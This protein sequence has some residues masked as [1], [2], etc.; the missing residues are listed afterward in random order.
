MPSI[1]PYF[2]HGVA[3]W[4]NERPYV[5][6][7]Q[8]DRATAIGFPLGG[9][10]VVKWLNDGSLADNDNRHF[11]GSVNN[12][13][14]YG[15]MIHIHGQWGNVSIEH[16]PFLVAHAGP[17]PAQ[18]YDFPTRDSLT[19]VNCRP[20]VNPIGT[21]ARIA[22]GTYWISVAN[23][24]GAGTTYRWV[25]IIPRVD[26]G[27]VTVYANLN[28]PDPNVPPSGILATKYSITVSQDDLNYWANTFGY[29]G[30]S[31]PN[32]EPS[33]YYTICLTNNSLHEN[34]GHDGVFYVQPSGYREYD[35]IPDRTELNSRVAGEKALYEDEFLTA[36]QVEAGTNVTL[37]WRNIDGSLTGYT[38]DPTKG[39]NLVIEATGGGGAT[40]H[41]GANANT[42]VYYDEVT[43]IIRFQNFPRLHEEP[44]D[45]LIPIEFQVYKAPGDVG[46][47]R[48]YGVNNNLYVSRGEGPAEFTIHTYPMVDAGFIEDQT[49]NHLRFRDTP[50]IQWDLLGTTMPTQTENGI[51]Y[52]KG[53]VVRANA[54]TAFTGWYLQELNTVPQTQPELISNNEIV[55]VEG[56]NGVVCTLSLPNATTTRLQIDRPLRIYRDAIPVGAPNTVQLR[57]RCDLESGNLNWFGLPFLASS[58]PSRVVMHD[59]LEMDTVPF[60][61]RDRESEGFPGRRDVYGF[62]TQPHCM[63]QTQWAMDY[64]ALGGDG[65]TLG[66]VNNQVIDELRLGCLGLFQVNA[67]TLLPGCRVDYHVVDGDRLNNF[68]RPNSPGPVYF[69]TR[70]AATSITNNARYGN[71]VPRHPGLFRITYR[72]QGL[73]QIPTDV[74]LNPVIHPR[75]HSF[76]VNDDNPTN[77][78][79][80]GAEPPLPKHFLPGVSVVGGMWSLSDRIPQIGTPLQSSQAYAPVIN[81]RPWEVYGEGFIA[82]DGHTVGNT[83]V[84]RYN[85]GS[86]E[87]RIAFQVCYMYMSIEKVA[88]LRDIYKGGWY[89]PYQDL[90]INNE[91]NALSSNYIYNNF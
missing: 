47:I 48:A 45:G 24:T 42:S 64:D 20:D 5:G 36:S 52:R 61:V 18:N 15:L 34:I 63:A 55:Q 4:M 10:I 57:F 6:E 69:T 62:V 32:L 67:Q 11:R 28:P 41:Q 46:V 38:T 30:Q 9:N 31:L 21:I 56:V 70:Y 78:V 91:I 51:I 81:S 77:P 65:R 43:N 79:N 82:S 19:T 12:V 29:G 66:F 73:M 80:M 35:E 25:R 37:R 44:I 16:I 1:G 50:T 17:I 7:D 87:N 53:V 90:K 3:P 22:D 54:I 89:L 74:A 8:Q 58:H 88:N 75:I 14:R 33:T 59:H 68:N 72:V 27:L 60:M 49:V 13:P 39:G 23:S 84:L 40:R 76:I 83:V 86:G 26:E 85:P 2:S 71:L